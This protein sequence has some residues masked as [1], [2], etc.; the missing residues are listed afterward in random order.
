[1]IILQ[2]EKVSVNIQIILKNEIGFATV[3]IIMSPERNRIPD[4][5]KQER[6]HDLAWI[7]ENLHIFRQAARAAFESSGR[8]AIVVDTTSRP[9]GEGNPFGYFAQ[10]LLEQRDDED[11]KRMVSEYNPEEELVLV[12]IKSQDR[13]SAYRVRPQLK[14]G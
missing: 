4:W 14:S 9:T 6:E 5:A 7:G 2:G 13:T 1:M 11:I 10:E 3:C 12:L 8:G